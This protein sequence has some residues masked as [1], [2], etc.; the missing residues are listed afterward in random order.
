M[1]QQIVPVEYQITYGESLNPLIM[2]VSGKSSQRQQYQDILIDDDISLVDPSNSTTQQSAVADALTT[3][4]SD[5]YLAFTTSQQREVTVR[6]YQINPTLSTLLRGI[7]ISLSVW[8][9]VGRIPFE[10]ITT[11]AL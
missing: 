1:K 9:Y 11:L 8:V 3:T 6:P 4:S 2:E 5:W 7:I 10:A